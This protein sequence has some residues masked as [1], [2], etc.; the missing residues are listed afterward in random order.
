[1]AK[2][3]PFFRSALLSAVAIFSAFSGIAHAEAAG[4]ITI[5]QISP[6]NQY[7]QWRLA[8]P[9]GMAVNR[10]KDQSKSV[11]APEGQ[12]LFNVQPPEGAV[13]TIRFYENGT[14][15]NTTEGTQVAF[16]FSGNGT[17]RAEVSYRYEGVVVVESTPTGASFELKGPGGVR[18]TGKTPASFTRMPPL[19][20]TASFSALPGC[21]QPKPQSR[22]LRPNA[23]L[24]FE[25][26]FICDNEK[27][28]IENT[29]P[30][31]DK[32][33]TRSATTPATERMLDEQTRSNVR[34]FHS[35][36]QSETV[37]G[38]TVY[39]TVGVRNIGKTT[40][41]NVTL[42]EQFDA[43]KVSI[44]GA[45]PEGGV[46]RGS[47]MV[48][49]IPTIYAGQ[50]FSVTFPIKVNGDTLQ[51]EKLS[52]SARVSGDTVHAP[53][54]ELLS[55]MVYVGVVAMPATGW[56]ADILFALLSA[57]ALGVLTLTT[58]PIIRRKLLV[59][60]TASK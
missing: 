42:T 49:D 5:E 10:N 6:I 29:A 37:A 43:S 32:V 34:L 28:T 58:N 33:P 30:P 27:M 38:S 14:L 12:Y 4:T 40:L 2:N 22:T 55:K 36:N 21:Q 31:A 39:V 3:S 8:T 52:L 26:D 19:Y 7:G 16:A 50:S 18:Y 17:L 54:G 46:V 11:N 57:V 59:V 35:L 25:A 53:Q 15:L 47:V 41:N 1:M 20:F 9:M 51:G 44:V 24:N 48:W 23:V 60:P 56:K 13:T 45:L